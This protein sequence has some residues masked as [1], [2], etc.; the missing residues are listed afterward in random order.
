[1][2]TAVVTVTVCALGAAA[3]AGC[4][5]SGVKQVSAPPWVQKAN[6]ICTRDDPKI[7]AAELES[8]PLYF[9]YNMVQHWLAEQ[10]ALGGVGLEAQVPGLQTDG[11]R[12]FR[13]LRYTADPPPIDRAL[14]RMKRDAAAKGVHCS[15]GALPLNQLQ[16]VH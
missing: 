12:A 1:M 10:H 3:I 14:L 4:G 2:R 9:T 7:K 16:V 11:Q 13:L 5:S 15:F 6:A 8:P